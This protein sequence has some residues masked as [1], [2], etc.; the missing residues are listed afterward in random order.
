MNKKNLATITIML[1]TFMLSVPLAP[2]GATSMAN[3]GLSP[4]A[5]SADLGQSFTATVMVTDAPNLAAYDFKVLFNPDILQVTSVSLTGTLFDPN[6]QPVVIAKS[7][8]LNPIGVVREAVTFFGGAT[9]SASSGSVLVVNFQVNNPLLGTSSELPSAITID[10]SLIGYQFPGPGAYPIPHTV[11]GA[12]FAPPNT[13][14]V[15]SLGCRATIQGFSIVDHGYTDGLFCRLVNNGVI[16]HDAGAV[17]NW[18]SLNG[19]TGSAMGSVQT[20]APGQ[21]GQSN[22]AITFPVGVSANDIFI[23]TGTLVTVYSFPDGSTY[24]AQGSS[25]TFKI[26]IN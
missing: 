2:V 6:T 3:L 9:A 10:S 12:M 5:Y 14:G 11:S 25:Q 24:A 1:A 19:I 17:F 15:R 23:V 13:A 20:L 4:A 22:A 26:I 16:S 18:H 7:D 21:N 8:I